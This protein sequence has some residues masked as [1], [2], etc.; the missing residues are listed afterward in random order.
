MIHFILWV[1]TSM[2]FIIHFLYF[3]IGSIRTMVIVYN[4]KHNKA[5]VSILYVH[6]Y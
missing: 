1:V 2:L 4:I 6:K 3:Y 5:H